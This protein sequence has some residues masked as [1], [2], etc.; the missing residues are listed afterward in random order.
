MSEPNHVRP[1]GAATETL[2]VDEASTAA[3]PPGL[4]SKSV[5]IFQSVNLNL[6]SV[7][8]VRIARI[9]MWDHERCAD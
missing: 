5:R 4:P 3:E 6:A 8:L 1:V 9:G 7:S 2:E